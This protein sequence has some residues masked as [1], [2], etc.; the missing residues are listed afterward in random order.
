MRGYR[1][2]KP[3][4]RAIARQRRRRRIVAGSMAAAAVG[5]ALVMGILVANGG[6]ARIGTPAPDFTLRL[7]TGE[8]LTLKSLRGRPVVLTFWAPNCQHCRQGLPVLARIA[9]R[10]QDQGIAF[11]SMG[12]S[13]ETLA[14]TVQFVRE[15]PMPFPVGYDAHGEIASAYRVDST[16]TT[17]YI[18]RDGIIRGWQLGVG[19]MG[20]ADLIDHLHGLLAG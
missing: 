7:L 1:N 16:P 2:R 10:F 18:G 8:D 13:W 6:V 15:H 9:R 12:V 11:I 5:V 14:D 19:E 4:P 17:F 3:E 20:E